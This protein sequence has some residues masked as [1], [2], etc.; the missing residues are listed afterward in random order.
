[1]EQTNILVVDDELNVRQLLSKI[2]SKEGYRVYTACDGMEGL[3][4]FQ[5][6]NI[7]IIISDIKM[8][9]MNGIEFLHKVKEIEPDVGFILIT[10]FA[11]TETAIDAL[12]SGAQDYVTKPFDF[13]EILTAVKK[14]TISGHHG[15]NYLSN[16]N[17]S[18]EG[19]K[20]K[21]KSP[22]MQKILKMAKQVAGTSATVLLTGE[23]GTGKE[24]ISSA[25]HRWSSRCDNPLI[26][27]NCGAIPDNLL[28]SELFGYEKGAF[29]GAVSS[30]PGRFEFADTGTIFLDEIGDISPS[31][32]VKLLRVLQEKSF[33]RLGG[34]KS[35][36]TDVRIIAA[37]NKNLL[38]EV[39]KGNFREDLYYRLNV[40][41][42]HLP[43][44]RERHE[45]IE[46]LINYFLESSANISGINKP[47]IMDNDALECLKRYNWP[48]NI[49]ELEN[50]IE[51]CVVISSGSRI[52][53]DCLPVEIR[54]SDKNY[55]DFDDGEPLL[56]TAIDTKEKE[57]IQKAL[58][59]CNGNKTKAALALGISRRSLHRKLQ[60]YEMID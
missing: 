43:P 24:V 9:K 23:T 57:V 17:N 44:L 47:K 3:E 51:R 34:L 56:N 54:E 19:F 40:V 8:P 27:V 53:I 4:L 46:D 30:K 22:K 1:M 32:Q 28:E 20:E 14:L 38:K 15:Y 25:I 11:T 39:K 7:D 60:K 21:S 52:N 35:I 55:V 13:S 45:D 59:E 6:T 41:P 50:I 37:T 49:R 48:G 12:K 16:Q 29:T 31:L 36:V 10:A 42:I 18:R 5:T 26:K 2:L 58:Q 33:E